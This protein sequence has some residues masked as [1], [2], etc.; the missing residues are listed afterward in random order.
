[1]VCRT[2]KRV[3]EQTDAEQVQADHRGDE[4][5]RTPPLASAPALPFSYHQMELSAPTPVHMM[6]EPDG[7]QLSV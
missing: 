7:P 6:P 2:S 1:M 5:T 4:P 3:Y